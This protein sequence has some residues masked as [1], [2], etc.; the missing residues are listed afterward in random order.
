MTL[1][2][3]LLTFEIDAES[4]PFVLK[5][6]KHPTKTWPT[7]LTDTSTKPI[8]L[9]EHHESPLTG[10]VIRIRKTEVIIDGQTRVIVMIRDHSDSINME[11]I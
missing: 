7:G 1:E 10:R 3:A 6:K 2:E 4:A 11:K 8:D 9:L 5:V